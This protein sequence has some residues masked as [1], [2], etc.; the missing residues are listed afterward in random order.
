MRRLCVLIVLISLF[1]CSAEDSAEKAMQTNGVQFLNVAFQDAV[2]LARN[3][4]K[5]L[6][7]DFYRDG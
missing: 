1:A 6:L 7:V 2:T 3:G 5:V 4:N